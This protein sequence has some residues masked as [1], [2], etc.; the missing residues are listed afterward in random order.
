MAAGKRQTRPR[1]RSVRSGAWP[2]FQ[3]W[4][5]LL[6]PLMDS[7]V[8]ALVG[9]ACRSLPT[10]A[11][12][13]AQDGPNVCRVIGHAADALDHLSDTL[14]GPHVIRVAVRFG[15]FEQLTFDLHE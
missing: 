7:L 14:Q 1:T 15:A 3:T 12:F 2:F 11:E 6:H 9:S 10:P 5:A 13:V 4:P 8:V